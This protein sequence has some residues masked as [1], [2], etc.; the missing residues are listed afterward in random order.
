M[1]KPTAYPLLSELK[2][3]TELYTQRSEATASPGNFRLTAFM[4]YQYILAK[5]GSISTAPQRISYPVAFS[6]KTVTILSSV[7]LPVSNAKILVFREGS[8]IQWSRG[9]TRV[10]NILTFSPQLDEEYIEILI[11]K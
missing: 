7:D 4:I 6:G 1:G 3:G 8:L 11:Y 5:I 9:V 2:D 10:D